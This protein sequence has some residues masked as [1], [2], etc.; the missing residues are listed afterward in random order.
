[1]RWRLSQ[2][3]FLANALL[4]VEARLEWL[5]TQIDDMR[6]VLGRINAA[7]TEL[8]S[9]VTEMLNIL[10]NNPTPAQIQE[11]IDGMSTVAATLENTAAQYPAPPT[12]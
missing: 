4:R 1:M 6:S 10:K 3:W 9:D 5:M 11:V 12:P 2:F 8:A 7:T